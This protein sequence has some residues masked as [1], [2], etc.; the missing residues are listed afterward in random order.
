[1]ARRFLYFCFFFLLV[2]APVKAMVIVQKQKPPVARGA[3]LTL[4]GCIRIALGINPQVAA[5]GH[6]ALAAKSR[7]GEARSGYY[8]Q[9]NWQ[10]DYTY[11]SSTQQKLQQ[12][13]AFG[14]RTQTV[15]NFQTGPSVTQN[16]YDFGR[17]GSLVGEAEFNS[18]AASQDFESVSLSIDLAVKT[19]YYGVLQAQGNLATARKVVAQ[20][21]AHL[22][23]AQGFFAVGTVPKI[24]VVNARVT[25]SNAQLALIQSENAL[26]I[27]WQNLNNAMGVPDAPPFRIV[28]TLAYAP[29]PV[30]FPNALRKAY[31]NRPDLK[32]SIATVKSAEQS[33]RF[34]RAGYYPTLSGDAGYTWSGERLPLD[35]GWNAGAALTVPLFSGFL[36]KNQVDESNA[37]LDTAKDN[38]QTL[39][40]QIYLQTRQA[41]LNL[42]QAASSIATAKVGLRDAKENLDLANG[43]YAAG[44]G[45]YIEVTDALTTFTQAQTTYIN[46]L[47]SYRID[48]SN[49]ENAMGMR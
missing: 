22:K 48:Q 37:D 3:L 21:Q 31:A 45:N 29:Y 11:Y 42:Q 33:L 49:L 17:T 27:A 20:A 2:A 26:K 16:I 12:V 19:A 32:A 41:Y 35:H 24:D 4:G 7:I 23:Q 36:T 25:L 10:T 8:P 47:Y 14:S 13:Q 30:T 34:S 44:V 43:R 38:E 5:A 9:V 39:R 1:M 28:N 15:T 40:Q 46:A 18:K 6:T